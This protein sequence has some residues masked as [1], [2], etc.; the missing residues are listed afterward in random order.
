M[1]AIN[2]SSELAQN[3]QIRTL[4]QDVG[5][6]IAAAAQRAATTVN[7]ELTV[8]CWQIGTRLNTEVLHAQRAE[9]GAQVIRTLAQGLME[10]YGQ[11]WNEKNLRHCVQ[12]AHQFSDAS[13]VYSLSRQ[14]SWT[15]LRS[16][17]YLED[18]LKRDFYIEICKLE[19]WS[20]RQ[21]QERIK[22]MLFER[23]AISKKPQDT[24]RQ[25]LNTLKDTG[26]ISADLAFRDPY[27][28][29]F[30]GLK[31][32]YSET[33]LETAILDEL[34]QFI[35]ELGNDFAFMARQKRLSFSGRDYKID[36]LFYHRR[37]KC[38]V[39]IDLKIGE[40]EA[41]YK[42]QME[43]YLRWLEKHEHVEGENPPIGLILCAGK[44]Q[45]FVELMQLDSSNIRVAEYLTLL[46]SQELLAHKLH[47]AIDR[48]R[49]T[50]AI[51]TAS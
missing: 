5:G 27:I 17:I 11:R 4:A 45:E 39:A 42:G 12:L 31:N 48:A 20:V 6:L 18:P 21:L 10:Q 33:D 16:L 50:L 15:H 23:T 13:I 14:L 44:S 49:Q 19:R 22:S 43:L 36:L 34:Q 24:I 38:L 37:L 1:T 3:T 25:E 29:D 47:H 40:F 41:A 32:T 8:L 7:A 28:L 26:T 35:T 2:P 30:L 9:Y 51:Q 46:P